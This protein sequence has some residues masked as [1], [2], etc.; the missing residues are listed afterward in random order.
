MNVL[1]TKLH[2]HLARIT[3]IT[4]LEFVSNAIITNDKIHAHKERKKRKVME[5]LSS[6]A[7]PK[8]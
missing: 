8:Y 2:E 1:S 7:P 4:I 6:S 3:G 5:A